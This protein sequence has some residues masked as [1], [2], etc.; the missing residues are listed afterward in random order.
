MVVKMNLKQWIQKS[1]PWRPLLHIRMEVTS[2]SATFFALESCLFSNLGLLLPVNSKYPICSSHLCCQD[3]KSALLRFRDRPDLKPQKP[4][5]IFWWLSLTSRAA[6]LDLD[7][8][9]WLWHPGRHSQCPKWD[10]LICV[11][12]SPIQDWTLSG[13]Q[14]VAPPSCSNTAT[15]HGQHEASCCLL[16]DL[17][18]LM[19]LIIKMF[20]SPLFGYYCFS[21]QSG[22][23]IWIPFAIFVH[24][25]PFSALV[26]PVLMPISKR[27]VLRL[28]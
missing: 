26:F 6:C 28:L 2:S 3:C 20:L 23:S 11:L 5:S 21:T 27:T 19:L 10:T 13:T 4:S 17:H 18:F 9:S 7:I 12:S 16:Y 22:C 1:E 15:F 14:Q 24:I 8:V 25:S